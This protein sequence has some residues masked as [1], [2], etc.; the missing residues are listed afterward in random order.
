MRGIDELELLPLTTNVQSLRALSLGRT[1][2]VGS[3]D[4]YP[5]T[6]ANSSRDPLMP[7]VHQ[8]FGITCPDFHCD[9]VENPVVH[10]VSSPLLYISC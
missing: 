4:S 7:G 10:V 2:S 5:E 3:P 9:G 8:D 6:R 1:Y